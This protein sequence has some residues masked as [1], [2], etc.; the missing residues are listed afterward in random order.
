VVGGYQARLWGDSIAARCQEYR[1]HT[2]LQRM[3]EGIA[4]AQCVI[5]GVFDVS[6]RAEGIAFSPHRI[7]KLAQVRQPV[8][9]QIV[10]RHQCLLRC[11]GSL[12]RCK[13]NSADGVTPASGNREA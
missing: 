2:P 3:F 13:Q 1:R 5:F 8:C 10:Q 7:L 6:V 4:A 12:M 11:Y 9:H